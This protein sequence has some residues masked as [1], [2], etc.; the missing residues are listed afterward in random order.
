MTRLPPRPRTLSEV[1]DRLDQLDRE[2]LALQ[3][4][5]GALT[6]EVA[7][8]EEARARLALRPP[9]PAAFAPFRA[10]ESSYHDFD[11]HVVKFRESLRMTARRDSARAREI[12]QEAVKSAERDGKAARWDRLVQTG[13]KVLVGVAVGVLVTIVLYRLGMK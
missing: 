8:T 1:I 10:E 5:L 3:E 11:E 2:N 12:A 9:T 4:Q 13:W 7:R 6:A